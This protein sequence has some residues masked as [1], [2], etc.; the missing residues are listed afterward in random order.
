MCE[1]LLLF[2]VSSSSLWSVESGA[3]K[4]KWQS[5][6]KAVEKATIL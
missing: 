3:V 1:A 5:V 6:H 2:Y 4:K